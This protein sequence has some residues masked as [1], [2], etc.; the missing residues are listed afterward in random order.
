MD[1][2][3]NSSNM[4]KYANLLYFIVIFLFVKSND[5]KNETII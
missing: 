5:L 4:K 1:D 3:Y 2:S